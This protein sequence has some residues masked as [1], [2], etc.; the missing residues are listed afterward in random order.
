MRKIIVAGI[1]T[2]I[3]KTVASAILCEALEADY[4]KPVQSGDLSCTDSQRV[5]RL[6][7]NRKTHIHPEAYRLTNPISPHAAAAIDQTV[8][9]EN[10]LYIPSTDRDLIIEL[11]GGLMTPLRKDYLN[12]DWVIASHLPVILVSSYY[13]GSIN[14]TLL[15]WELLMRRK[16]FVLGIVFN[17][18]KNSSTFEAITYQTQATCLLEVSREKKLNASIIKKYASRVDL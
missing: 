8:I 15:S 12:I 18:E 10:R 1:D 5:R 17:G 11:A 16:V 14:H 13:L 9:N 2:G 3:G 6:V 4:W 7:S